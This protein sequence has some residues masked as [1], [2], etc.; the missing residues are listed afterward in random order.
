MS[1]TG[2]F[3]SEKGH[4]LTNAHVVEGCTA[5]AIT[6]S[7]SVA[8]KGTVIARDKTNDLAVIAT[9]VK[10]QSFAALRLGAKVGEP[11]SAFGYPLTGILTT[12]GNFTTGNISAT[13]GIGDD[14]RMLQISAPVQPGN[15]G[16]PL[17]DEAG[18][19]V[20]VVVAKLN[21]L[22]ISKIANDI[23]QNVNFAIKSSIAARADS[24]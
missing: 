6:P 20:G 11:V 8:S 2:F 9:D 4:I 10:P 22:S 7:A 1:G 12:T 16:G 14:T 19:V 13:A 17:L 3:V 23:P 21:A 18:N 15:S 5:V 24:I